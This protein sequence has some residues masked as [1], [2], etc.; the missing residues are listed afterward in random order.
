MS[1]FFFSSRRRHTR[2]LR[3]WS[4]DVCSSDLSALQKAGTYRV[5]ATIGDTQVTS[6]AFKVDENALAKATIPSIVN[7]YFRQRATS[8]EEWAADAAVQVND[9]S[10]KVD[11]RGGW[12]D[13]SGDISKYFSHLAYANFLS[14][15]QSPMVA[16]E[17]AD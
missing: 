4:S 12:T 6:E 16:W 11:M 14:P 1:I 13:A 2:S 15:Q 9:G 10:K 8:A 3:D 5:R 7:Y 17:L